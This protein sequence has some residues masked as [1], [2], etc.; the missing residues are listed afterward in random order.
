MFRRSPLLGAAVVYGASRSAA[1]REVDR[2]EMRNAEMQREADRRLYDQE[3]RMRRDQE[4]QERREAERRERERERE[5]EQELR[6]QRAI[7]AALG[8]ERARMAGSYGGPLQGGFG[9]QQQQQP[10]SPGMS[11]A[12]P[13]PQIMPMGSGAG[14]V[15]PNVGVPV[16]GGGQGRVEGGRKCSACGKLCQ[17]QD[18]FCGNCGNR[19]S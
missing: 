16:G 15:P 19:L 12:A 14:V 9:G 17:R 3:Q 8:Q 18:K 11:V 4:R 6:I 10:L 2:N 1:R 5:G 13:P 7:D